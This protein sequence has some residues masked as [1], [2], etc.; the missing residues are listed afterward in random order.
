MHKI[1]VKTTIKELNTCHLLDEKTT[2]NLKCEEAKT[3][4]FKMAPEIYEEG[5]PG[6]PIVI[7]TNCHNN[8]IW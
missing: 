2:S 7:S 6:Q 8:N 4:G 3:P 1:K 5:N